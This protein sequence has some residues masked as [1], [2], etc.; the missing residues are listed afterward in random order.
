[1]EDDIMVIQWVDTVG[2]VAV[3]AEE[4]EWEDE[5]DGRIIL[6]FD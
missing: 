3:L 6:L 2:L 5:G 4:G 1:V